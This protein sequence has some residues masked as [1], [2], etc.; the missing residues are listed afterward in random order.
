MQ[1]QDIEKA[2]SCHAYYLRIVPF[3]ARTGRALVQKGGK[4]CRSRVLMRE[5]DILEAATS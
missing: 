5:A 3:A 1:S 4:Q 2:T